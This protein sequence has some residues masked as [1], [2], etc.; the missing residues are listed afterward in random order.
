MMGAFRAAAAAIAF[1]A[2]SGALAQDSHDWSGFR[3]G[4]IGAGFVGHA[5]DIPDGA[6][7]AAFGISGAMLGVMGR[8]DFDFGRLVAGIGVDWTYNTVG[9][10]YTGNPNSGTFHIDHTT[11]V[12]F[13]VGYGAGRNLVY[14]Q[15]GFNFSRV[16]TSGGPTASQDTD[17]VWFHSGLSQGYG[18]HFGAG[19]EHAFNRWVAGFVEYRHVFVGDELIDL[20]PTNPGTAHFVAAGGHTIRAGVTLRLGR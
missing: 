10:G 11:S 2:G 12:L 8:F 9:G 14:V 5:S 19:V 1:C 6:P 17:T 7:P 3:V 18:R 4:V 13:R 16:T 15:A 20:G